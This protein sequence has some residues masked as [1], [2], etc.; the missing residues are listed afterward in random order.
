MADTRDYEPFLIEPDPEDKQYT[1][2]TIA[3]VTHDEESNMVFITNTAGWRVALPILSEYNWRSPIPTTGETLRVYHSDDGDIRGM[4][5]LNL[6]TIFYRTPE[7]HEQFKDHAANV[8]EAQAQ[9]FSSR[10]F[11]P[12]GLPHSDDS[13]TVEP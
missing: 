1:D 2:S 12:S 4:E 8:E 6:R 11:P 13:D 10:L 3:R 7:M 9:R 5:I